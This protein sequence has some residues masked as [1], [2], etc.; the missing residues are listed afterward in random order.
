[1]IPVITV[2]TPETA[3]SVP[4][5]SPA[6]AETLASAA[7][8]MAAPAPPPAEPSSNGDAL[9]A[10]NVLL[11]AQLEA[12]KAEMADSLKQINQN[13]A[14]AHELQQR[15]RA[16]R[17]RALL[18]LKTLKHT[19]Q[20]EALGASILRQQIRSAR[21]AFDRTGNPIL[22][23]YLPIDQLANRAVDMLLELERKHQT[24]LETI[25]RLRAEARQATAQ[26]EK[27]EA[28]G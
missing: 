14:A 15:E 19:P 4:V 28:H 20:G 3:A 25:D 8:A 1:V 18:A 2:P 22:K 27:V 7:A 12:L 13:L 21:Q 5:E 16:K 26:A 23:V 11:R 24:A 10:E 9:K 6:P 17:Q